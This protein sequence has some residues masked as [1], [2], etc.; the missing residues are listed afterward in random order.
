[1]YESKHIF[2]NCN[3]FVETYKTKKKTVNT[4][5]DAIITNYFFLLLIIK[6]K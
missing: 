6:K 3:C 1:M 5:T 2:L 4:H